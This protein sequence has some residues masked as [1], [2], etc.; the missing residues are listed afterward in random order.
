MV[1][2]SQLHLI[3]II[4]YEYLFHHFMK[5]SEMSELWEAA[6]SKNSLPWLE[7]PPLLFSELPQETRKHQHMWFFAPNAYILKNEWPIRQSLELKQN[8]PK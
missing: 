1:D 2:R 3:R 4:D 7:V 8:Q 5:L 6:C